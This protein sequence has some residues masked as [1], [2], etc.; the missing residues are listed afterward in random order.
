MNLNIHNKLFLICDIDTNNVYQCYYH[1]KLYHIVNFNDLGVYPETK[2]GD[3][4][5]CVSKD[6]NSD[7]MQSMIKINLPEKITNKIIKD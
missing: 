5:Q 7:I 3:I 2:D 4:S 1:D 6:I